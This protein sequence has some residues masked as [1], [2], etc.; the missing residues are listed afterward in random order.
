MGKTYRRNENRR[1]K[2]DKFGKKSKKQRELE[3][4]RF[5]PRSNHSLKPINDK[6]DIEP[7]LFDVT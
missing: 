2:W 5:K 1:P 4:G 7:D 6:D 3:D